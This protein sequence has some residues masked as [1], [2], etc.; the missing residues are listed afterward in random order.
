MTSVL[1]SVRRHTVTAT[2]LGD[3]TLVATGDTVEGLY[4]PRHWRMPD[5]VTFGPRVDDGFDEVIGQ[6]REYLGGSRREFTVPVRA[7]G[8]ALQRRTWDLIREIPYGATTS[9][10]ALA[11]R[12]GAGVDAR[13]AGAMIGANPLC[14]LIPCHRV[15][16]ST[17]KLTGYAGGLGR[18]R[19]LLDIERAAGEPSSRSA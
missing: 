1:T 6:L 13:Q 8:D 7:Q 19:L 5:Q 2:E 18:K 4:F 14:I 16:G 9:Y 15:I 17:G 12:L 3:I 10:A 11:A